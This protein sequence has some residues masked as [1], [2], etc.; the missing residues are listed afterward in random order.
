MDFQLILNGCQTCSMDLV[1]SS[2]DEAK[3]REGR[4]S[5]APRT[6]RHPQAQRG[7]AHEANATE[8]GRAPTVQ[9]GG[10]LYGCFRMVSMQ[11]S[12]RRLRR[13]PEFL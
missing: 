3:G 8:G 13:R 7:G 2:G 4:Q 12:A 5:E 9:G 1:L 6:S 11:I 10:R